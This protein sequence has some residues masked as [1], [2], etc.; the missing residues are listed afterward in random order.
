MSSLEPISFSFCLP[1]SEALK[2]Q[3]QRNNVIPIPKPSPY[4]IENGNFFLPPRKQPLTQPV[5]PIYNHRSPSPKR[6]K[7]PVY[8]SIDNYN[9]RKKQEFTD[10]FTLQAISILQI[11]PNSLFI[12]H[13]QPLEPQLHRI[14]ILQNE[15]KQLRNTLKAQSDGPSTVTCLPSLYTNRH[16]FIAPKS[17]IPN[18]SNFKRNYNYQSRLECIK[19]RNKQREK[20]AEEIALKNQEEAHRRQELLIKANQETKKRLIDIELTRRKRAV[21]HMQKIE[22]NIVPIVF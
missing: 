5:S 4:E 3:I 8:I 11:D 14:S 2:G 19:E 17:L 12:D 1:S 6:Y 22:M 7:L 20:R 21:T 9:I 15:I 16:P 13:Q 10:K 18:N